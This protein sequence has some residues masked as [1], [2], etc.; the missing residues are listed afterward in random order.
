M[1]MVDPGALLAVLAAVFCP[2][3]AAAFCKLTSV[4]LPLAALVVGALADPSVGLVFSA[5]V[6]HDHSS[7]VLQVVGMMTH[8]KLFH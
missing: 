7:P 3:T 6:P 4:F 2:P 5:Q 1:T 8:G